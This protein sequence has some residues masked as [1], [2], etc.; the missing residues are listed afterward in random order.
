MSNL[1][2]HSRA[3]LCFCSLTL[4]IACNVA[5]ASGFRS[6]SITTDAITIGVYFDAEGTICHGAIQPG[7]PGT[8]Y[9]LAKVGAGSNGIA[10]A[11]FRFSGVPSSWATFP[12]ANP[13]FI[14]I[15]NPFGD[16]VNLGFHCQSPAN[17]VVRL[18]SVLV[19][20]TSAETDVRFT[21]E[22]HNTPA[23]Q[24]FHC[25]LAVACEGPGGG[26]REFCIPGVPCTVNPSRPEPCGGPTATAA[27][28]WS[29]VKALFQ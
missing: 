2:I 9:V 26:F 6:E 23:N 25:P 22:P 15:G 11:E 5:A 7:V 27:A 19:L 29:S 13:D 18:Y 16:G 20:A 10:G 21:I 17:G 8:V 24:D 28:S 12:V 4:L 14:T 3:A 1:R